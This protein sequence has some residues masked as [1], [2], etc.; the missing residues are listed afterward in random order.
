MTGDPRGRTVVVVGAGIV[1]TA[2]AAAAARRGHRVTVIDRGRPGPGATAAAMGHVVAPPEPPSLRALC[3]Y[4]RGLWRERAG[5]WRGRVPIREGGTLWLASTREDAGAI[6]AMVAT[7]RAQGAPVEVLDG[8]AARRRAPALAPGIRGAAFVPDDLL[9][10]PVAAAEALR[11]EAEG[12]GAAFRLGC[13]VDR[14]VDRGVVLEGGHTVLGE[15]VVVAAGA[16]SSRLLPELRLVPRKGHVLR[17]APIPGIGTAELA[18]IG[19]WRSTRPPAGATAVAFNAQPLPD[20]S[21]D[22]GASRADGDGRADP[23]PETVRRLLERAR[24]FLPS[25]GWASVRSVRTGPRPATPDGLPYLG[26]VAGRDGVWVA[27]GHEGLGITASLG[28]AEVVAALLDGRAAPVPIGDFAPS[29]RVGGSVG[30]CG[31]ESGRR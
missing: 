2:I 5:P 20:G 17:L 31:T 4:S 15:A 27:T 23:E 8:P 16:V 13:A 25:L 7:M 28:T 21:V 18:E 6:D 22:L 9:V 10:D 24:S 14:L 1:G 3:A 30:R 19:Y 29:R 26:P 11:A 12:A